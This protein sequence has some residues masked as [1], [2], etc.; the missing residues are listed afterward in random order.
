MDQDLRGGHGSYFSTTYRPRSSWANVVRYRGMPKWQETGDGRPEMRF[1]VA[2]KSLSATQRTLRELRNQGL[3]CDVA[4]KWNRWAGPPR[5]DGSGPVGCRQDLF[6]FV[7]IIALCPTRGILAV[8]S[9][10]NSHAAHLKKMREGSLEYVRAWLQCGGSIELWTWRKIKVARGGKAER[11][12]PRI[13][14]ITL[15]TLED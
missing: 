2:K 4:E 1:G 14:T 5:K 9:C 6:T 10:S 8:Q 12:A 13:E 11:W 15:A 7:D 3:I